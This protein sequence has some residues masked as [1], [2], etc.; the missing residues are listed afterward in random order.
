MP[1]TTLDSI[2]IGSGQ[3]GKPLAVALAN[4][5]RQVAL[6]EREHLGGTCVNTGCTPT[7]TMVASARVAHLVSRAAEYGIRVG[8]PEI[9]MTIVRQRKRD[10]VAAFRGGNEKSVDQTDN[11][12]LIRGDA[13]FVSEKKLRVSLNSGGEREITA[14][15]IVI[16]TGTRNVVPN[17][18]GVE[19]VETLDSTSIMELDTVPEHLIVIG[20]GYIGLEFSQMFRRFGS[21]V[22]IFQRAD[23]LLD[24]EDDDVTEAIADILREDGIDIILNADVSA[25]QKHGAGIKVELKQG[26]TVTGSHLMFATGRRPNTD[27]LQVEAAGI[28]LDERGFVKVNDRLETSVKGIYAIGDVT[29]GP[30]FT[31]ISYDDYRI[32]Q[33]N[34][35]HNDQASTKHRLVPYTL[36][37]DPQLGR[38][39]L[40]EKQAKQA[41]V[42]YKVAKI[43]MKH[44]A[45]A[46]ETDETR[47]FMK[48]LVDPDT[49]KILGCAVLGIEGGEVMAVIQVAMM[50]GLPYPR[51]RDAALAH[52]TLAESLNNLFA[53]VED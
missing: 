34:I 40:S 11:L 44:V 43:P 14:D 36:F 2:I 50:A 33:K 47:G 26:K 23:H 51:L 1:Q 38:V 27:S 12:E 7:K 8:P 29:G 6:V 3:G 13:S 30:A 53:G 31:H 5:G 48:V 32:L 42:K 41:V 39:G 19:T 45:R 52:P 15:T 9:D 16:D 25:V 18:K 21:N 49:K 37:T 24:R 46:L 20:G 28:E 22:T 10:I 4:A 17:I 35:L